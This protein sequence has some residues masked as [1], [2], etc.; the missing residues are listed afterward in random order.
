MD[1][2]MD[3]WMDV[4]FGWI[5]VW[6]I[7]LKEEIRSEAPNYFLWVDLIFTN[8]YFALDPDFSSFDISGIL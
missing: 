5:L 1:R 8:F 2:W 6:V 7:I 3:G 4:H